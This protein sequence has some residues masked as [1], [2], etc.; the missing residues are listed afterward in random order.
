MANER[1]CEEH[2]AGGDSR[3]DKNNNSSDKTY[4]KKRILE[5]QKPLAWR[6][7]VALIQWYKMYKIKHN[8]KHIVFIHCN[9]LK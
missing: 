6:Q 7:A 4:E 9:K 3:C 1:P 5:F 8:F 2:E